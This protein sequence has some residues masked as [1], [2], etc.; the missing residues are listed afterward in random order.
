MQEAFGRF[1]RLHFRPNFSQPLLFQQ[2]VSHQKEVGQHTYA[3]KMRDKGYAVCLVLVDARQRLN[4][5]GK[6]L[7][8][9]EITVKKQPYGLASLAGLAVPGVDYLRALR[10]RTIAAPKALKVFDDFDALI[11]PTL[12][13]LAGL[14]AARDR[15]VMT[16]FISRPQWGGSKVPGTFVVAR[17]GSSRVAHEQLV[18]SSRDRTDQLLRN[19]PRVSAG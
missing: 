14:P 16:H 19:R 15:R 10:I 11:A 12:L 5:H 7:N 4:L 1:L 6:L 9:L 13:H 8:N 2:H 3:N 18:A 17:C